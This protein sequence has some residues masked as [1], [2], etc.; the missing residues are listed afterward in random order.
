MR[1][2]GAIRVLERRLCEPSGK[3]HYGDLTLYPT[4]TRAV[5]NAYI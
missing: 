2:S 1:D 3:I 5:F 4:K